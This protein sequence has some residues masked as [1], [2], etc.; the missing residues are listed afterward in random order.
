MFHQILLHFL[1]GFEDV[2]GEHDQIFALV[3]LRDVVEDRVR[4]AAG[5]GSLDALPPQ[6]ERQAEAHQVHEAVPAHGEGPQM[7]GD[8]IEVRVD[9]HAE[10]GAIEGIVRSSRMKA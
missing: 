4:H 6:P 5:S 7:D 3:F 1:I 9:E 10:V 8:R 2:D